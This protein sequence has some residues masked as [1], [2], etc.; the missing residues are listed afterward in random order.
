MDT[1]QATPVGSVRRFCYDDEIST[2]VVMAVADAKGVDPLELEPIY[3]VIDPDALNRVFQ[4][5][6][7]SARDSLELQFSMAGCDVV[8]RGDGEVVVTPPKSSETTAAISSLEN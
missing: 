2:T 7:G 3:S 6:V 5:T 1:I 4:P 8:V